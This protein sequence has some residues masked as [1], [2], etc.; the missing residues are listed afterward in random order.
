[1]KE[2]TRIENPSH[3]IIDGN[4]DLGGVRG[5]WEERGKGEIWWF[6]REMPLC[7]II[8]A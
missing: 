6:V 7:M 4:P 3:S 5:E 2:A 1:M 8:A